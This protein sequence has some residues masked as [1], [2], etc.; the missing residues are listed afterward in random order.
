MK[1]D[2]DILEDIL[3]TLGSIKWILIFLL[4]VECSKMR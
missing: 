4:L 1:I 2:R 3:S